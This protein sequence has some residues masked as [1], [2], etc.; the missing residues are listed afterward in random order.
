LDKKT[1][2]IVYSTPL[3]QQYVVAF[4]TGKHPLIPEVLDSLLSKM[5][6]E[7][8]IKTKIILPKEAIQI[9]NVIEVPSII[10][11]HEIPV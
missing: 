6:T 5:V 10:G 8:S 4:H 7:L 1:Y 3:P 9:I 2:Y 11:K